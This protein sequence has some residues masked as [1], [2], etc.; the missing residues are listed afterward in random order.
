MILNVVCGILPSL[1]EKE[2]EKQVCKH[3]GNDSLWT[4]D[5]AAAVN[6]HANERVFE[7]APAVAVTF[8]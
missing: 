6:A 8:V 3:A 1:R 7:T 4:S 2:K 5:N